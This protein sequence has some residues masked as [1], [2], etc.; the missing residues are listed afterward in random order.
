MRSGRSNRFDPYEMLTVRP[1][2]SSLV[3]MTRDDARM[4]SYVMLVLCPDGSVTVS[5]LECSSRA[6][7]VVLPNGSSI[8]SGAPNRSSWNFVVNPRAF[9]TST[10]SVSG[11]TR[12][13]GFPAVPT[14][15]AQSLAA[16]G[17]PFTTVV[18]GRVG[19]PFTVIDGSVTVFTTPS[20]SDV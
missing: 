7:T 1:V 20:E 4:G 11:S 13:L 14:P 17:R 16:F 3:W 8:R 18:T 6:I 5:G 2:V 15:P 19:D 12:G 10:R 9:V